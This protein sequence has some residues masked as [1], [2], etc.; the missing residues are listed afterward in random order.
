MK[1][2]KTQKK[3]HKTA[4]RTKDGL[5]NTQNK[6]TNNIIPHKTAD[7]T[8]AKTTV[9]TQKTAPENTKQLSL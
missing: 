4:I 1:A 5:T 8:A 9:E 6:S 3:N 7:K 2:H